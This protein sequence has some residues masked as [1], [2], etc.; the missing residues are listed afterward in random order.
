MFVKQL[1]SPGIDFKETVPPA[2]EARRD[3]FLGIDP[4]LLKI[5]AQFR[6]HRQDATP[7]FG[8]GGGWGVGSGAF[9]QRRHE[10]V[11]LL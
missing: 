7:T 5:R 11:G 9:Q 4:G 1:R 8:E 2:Y 3:R 6:E 10:G